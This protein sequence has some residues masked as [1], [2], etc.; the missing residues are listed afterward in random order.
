MIVLKL[1][2]KN[3]RGGGSY[4]KIKNN[5]EGQGLN[6]YFSFTPFVLCFGMFLHDKE[7]IIS[8]VN[9]IAIAQTAFFS[10]LTV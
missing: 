2:P 4:I 8:L 1:K 7:W 10:G 6:P 5:W 3:G 9:S